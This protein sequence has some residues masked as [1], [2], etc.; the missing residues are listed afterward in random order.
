MTVATALQKSCNIF[1][2]DAVRRLGIDT[3]EKYGQLFGF[4]QKTGIEFSDIESPGILAGNT[5]RQSVGAELMRPGEVLLAA[6]GQSDNSVTPLQLANYAATIANGGVRMVP[7]IIKSVR[8]SDTGEIIMETEPEVAV[9]LELSQST[10]DAVTDGMV[11]VAQSG[12]GL[13]SAFRDYTITSVAVKT[14]TAETTTGLPNALIVGF[15]PAED[16]KVAFAVVVEHGGINV[17]PIV[18]EV[19]KN[20]L[21]YYFSNM[22]SLDSV[23]EEGTLNP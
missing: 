20:A 21:S 13:Y 12:G 16:P 7:H 15:A 1:F 9:D 5:Y 22:D 14:G 11:K 17:G 6:I 18:A 10:I 3:F 8:N 4:G 19:I 2:F 23:S